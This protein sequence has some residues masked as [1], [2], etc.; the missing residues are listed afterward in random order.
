VVTDP[1][2]AR[3]VEEVELNALPAGRMVLLGPWLLRFSEGATRRANSVTPLAPAPDSAVRVR[4]C[5]ERYAAQ[6]LPC[7][8]R[9]PSHVAHGLDAVLDAT[10]FAPAEGETRTLFRADLAGAVADGTVRMTAA[11]D[12][13]WLEAQRRLRGEASSAVRARMLGALAIPA[14]FAAAH[15]DGA[16]LSLAYGALHQ[17][18]VAINMVITDPAAQRRGLARR[19]LLHLLAWARA[20]GARAACLQVQADNAAATA[21]YEGLGFR[22]ELYRY[23]YRRLATQ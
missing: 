1:D 8:F 19:V 11:P 13:A 22:T 14:A 12:A 3:L 10:G 4:A 20:A 15:E 7:L 6:G 18:V 9:L 21:L 16:D 5:I 2:L 23:H 17:G